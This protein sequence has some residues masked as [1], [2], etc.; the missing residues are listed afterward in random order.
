MRHGERRLYKNSL[1]ISVPSWFRLG[2][3]MVHRRMLYF[4]PSAPGSSAFP[5]VWKIHLPAS[6]PRL[7]PPRRAA[8][9]DKKK[10]HP[11]VA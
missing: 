5:G 3:P 8:S 10:S 9:S 7:P 2:T 4:D 6:G 1:H 11:K